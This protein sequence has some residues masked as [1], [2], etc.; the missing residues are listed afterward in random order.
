MAEN[1]NPELDILYKVSNYRHYKLQMAGI[2]SVEEEDLVSAGY[3]GFVEAI[4]NFEPARSSD[5]IAYAAVKINYAISQYLRELD[6]IDYRIRSEL[7]KL[8]KSKEKYFAE[9]GRYP[10]FLELAHMLKI[11]LETVEKLTALL[12]VEA[13]IKHA[14][15]VEE[16]MPLTSEI[17][18][19]DTVMLLD[20]TNDCINTLN[21]DTPIKILSL[22]IL[23]GLKTKEIVKLIGADY[24]ATKITRFIKSARKLLKNC[25]QGKG[26]TVLDIEE[27]LQ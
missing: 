19:I 24:S 4:A 27:V 15:D 9:H 18:D 17:E 20:D 13:G 22:K 12:E 25:L 21:D 6:P 26:W 23:K 8:K 2:R 14:Q 10:E 5:F 3:F 7:K 16:Y 1:A 11:S